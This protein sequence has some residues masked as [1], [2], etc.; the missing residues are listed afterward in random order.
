METTESH[1]QIS[2]PAVI[3]V[4]LISAAGYRFVET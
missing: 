1:G 3:S 2:V 4:A